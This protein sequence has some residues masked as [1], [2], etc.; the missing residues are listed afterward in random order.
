MKDPAG[1]GYKGSV[2]MQGF[3]VSNC[4]EFFVRFESHSSLTDIY[5]EEFYLHET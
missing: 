5:F 3:R 1:V 4:K 2:E